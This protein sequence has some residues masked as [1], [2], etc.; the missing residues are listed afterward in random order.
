MNNFSIVIPCFNESDV[1]AHTL[2][3]LD[4]YLIDF[5]KKNHTSVCKSI[6][7]VNDG[8]TDNTKE[9]ILEISDNYSF[10]II[11]I[12]LSANVGHQSALIAGLDYCADKYDFCVSMDADLQD[13]ITVISKMI[14]DFDKGFDMVLG[15]R[16][17]RDT[18]TFFKRHSALLYYRFLELL[19][20][21]IIFN[22]ADFRLLSNFVLIQLKNF[23]EK[24][25][26]L[27]ALILK[28]TNNFSIVKYNRLSRVY[29][30][31]KYPLLK[32]LSLAWSGVTSFSFVPLK[33]ITFLG[34]LTFLISFLISI[35]ALWG[36]ISTNT[37]PGWFS[38]V[39]PIYVLGGLIMFS[40]GIVGEYISKIYIETKNR[41]RFII[42]NIFG[43]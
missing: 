11:L 2:K 39:F 15:V 36:F 12:D 25:L 37:I 35:Y 40:L 10:S 7:L 3:S 19:G 20:V 27:R 29:G 21:D 33:V 4:N 5:H 32:M 43:D 17:S 13:D 8:S 24:S 9:K 42:K 34:L 18:D 1:I 41:P 22:H 14:D 6:V 26:F 16:D 30:E 31:T 23:P 38:T 28:I